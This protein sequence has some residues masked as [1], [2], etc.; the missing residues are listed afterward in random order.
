MRTAEVPGFCLSGLEVCTGGISHP[1]SCGAVCGTC[2][3]RARLAMRVFAPTK[4]RRYFFFF[5]SFNLIH[6][7]RRT[8][9]RGRATL[10]VLRKTTKMVRPR[11]VTLPFAFVKLKDS[12]KEKHPRKSVGAKTR[13]ARRARR[14]HVPQTASH[15]CG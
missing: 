4:F 6:A 2:A 5:E 11:A 9:T 14:A 1:H 10:A 13:M 8:T 12:Q 3:R 7:N 15:A